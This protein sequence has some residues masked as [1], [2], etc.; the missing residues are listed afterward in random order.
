M[1]NALYNI[2]TI[3]D[4][5]KEKFKQLPNEDI[6]VKVI[7]IWWDFGNPFGIADYDEVEITSFNWNDDPLIV[8]YRKDTITVATLNLTY[9]SNILTK[10]TRS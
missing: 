4:L 8:V 6:W 5:E 3:N 2:A 9:S 1:D 7:W 10:I